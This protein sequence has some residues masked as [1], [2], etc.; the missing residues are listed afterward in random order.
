LL[1]H[2]LELFFIT[3]AGQK[4]GKYHDFGLPLY[5]YHYY[6]PAKIFSQNKQLKLQYL[7]F[8]VFKV[9]L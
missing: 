2:L 5:L 8:D 7:A 1:L 4:A 3:T 6:D 9:K